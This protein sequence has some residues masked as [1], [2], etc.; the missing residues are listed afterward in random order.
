ML[1]FEKELEKFQPSLEIEEVADVIRHNDVSDVAD[2]IKEV[3][4]ETRETR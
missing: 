1:D 4:I 3:L 2:L